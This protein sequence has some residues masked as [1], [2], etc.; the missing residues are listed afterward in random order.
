[1]VKLRRPLLVLGILIAGCARSHSGSGGPRHASVPPGTVAL[2]QIA[3]GLA[4]PVG[5]E[6]PDDGTGRLFILEQPGTIRIFDSGALLPADF[7]D[8][9]SKVNFDGEQGLLGL[10]FHPDYR[11]NR[12]FI[13]HYDRLSGAAIQSVIAEYLT[14]NSD[15]AQAD[16][17][18]ERILLT[19]DQPF[20]NHKGGQ[21]AFGA[22]GF[23]YLAL[24]DGGSGGDPL[25]H[26]Q[27]LNVLL[28]KILR[29]DID[30][31]SGGNQ[32]AIPTDNPFAGGGGLPEIWA[33]G[34]RNPWRF[35]F[36]GP[37]GRLFCADVGQSAREEIDLIVKGGN[38]GWNTMEGTLCFNPP[39]GCSS[40]GLI[41]PIFDYGH[42][43]GDAVIGGFVYRGS[44]IPSLAGVY[45]FG[46]LDAGKVWCLQ[47]GP[48]GTWTRST[49][50]ATG[51]TL[52]S[53]GEDRAGE[54]YVIDYS[55]A[56]LQIVPR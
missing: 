4:S 40:A 8:I 42:D 54:L 34:L 12:K 26:G 44:A 47:E 10:A 45:I 18:S 15:P 28:G 7:L 39:N 11:N 25:G 30:A 14:S 3:G 16:P 19:V 13:I 56:L 22:D 32:Y 55:G 53:F 49:L 35:S 31:T 37:T 2:Q 27:D 36:D 43:E 29:I 5:L 33:Y 38:Y 20:G 52:S 6:A 21:L 9:R 23:L 46:D 24:G 41:P 1:M 51:R 17:A 50:F 48:S